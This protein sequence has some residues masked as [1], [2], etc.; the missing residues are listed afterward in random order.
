MTE[1]DA[2]KCQRFARE[3]WWYVPVDVELPDEFGLEI[4]N[5]LGRRHG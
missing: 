1:K 2:V 4:I 5:L 3:N